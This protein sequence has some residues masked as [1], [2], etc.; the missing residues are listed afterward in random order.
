MY[1][2]QNQQ[3]QVASTFWCA[4]WWSNYDLNKSIEVDKKT[5]KGVGGSRPNTLLPTLKKIN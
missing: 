1:P 2:T 3:I 5:G 4:R